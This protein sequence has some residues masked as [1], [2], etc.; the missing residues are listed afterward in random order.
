MKNYAWILLTGGLV[1][2]AFAS[3]ACGGGGGDTGGAGG[4]A[5]T[6]SSSTSSSSSSSVTTSTGTG[7]TT[8]CSDLVQS[9][10]CGDCLVASCCK[11]LEACG[12]DQ[13]CLDCATGN[14]DPAT[15]DGNAAYEGYTTCASTSCSDPCTPKSSCNPVTNEGCNAAGGEACDLNS[16]GV[17]VCF[18]PTNDA[19]LCAACSNGSAGPYCKAGTHCAED[20]NGGKCTAYCC[21]DEDC[22]TGK[23]DMSAMPSG[24]GVCTG[25]NQEIASCDSPATPPSGGTCYTP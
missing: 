9:G 18:P 12:N 20:A 4:T 23:C 2:F 19:A 3:G 21:T 10:A 8:S 6:T 13:D 5:P 11:E 14:V 16:S 1:S 17:F 22:G 25:A 7:T 24:V 15:C